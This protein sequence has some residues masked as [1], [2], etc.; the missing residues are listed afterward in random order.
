MKNNHAQ[1]RITNLSCPHYL[2]PSARSISQSDAAVAAA[3][4]RENYHR[5]ARVKE[6]RWNSTIG[7]FKRRCIHE[8]RKKSLALWSRDFLSPLVGYPSVK[9]GKCRKRG[10]ERDLA[11]T[12]YYIYYHDCDDAHRLRSRVEV[13]RSERRNEGRKEQGE[14]TGRRKAGKTEQ[15]MIAT[16]HERTEARRRERRVRKVFVG[17]LTTANGPWP[18]RSFSLSRPRKKGARPDGYLNAVVCMRVRY[19]AVHRGLESTPRHGAAP[20]YGNAVSR[21]GSRRFS[22][23][24]RI[25]RKR[26]TLRALEECKT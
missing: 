4:V 5:C 10:R 20:W 9:H 26:E 22:A 25:E 8:I 24:T 1:S 23:M 12:T 16:R 3:L 18:R 13:S 11:R 14:G 7:Y 2:L 6:R 19:V 15:L 21:P 17:C